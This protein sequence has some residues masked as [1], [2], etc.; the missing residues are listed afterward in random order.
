MML[1]FAKPEVRQWAHAVVDRLVQNYELE[2]IKI[3][4]NIDVGSEFDPAAQQ[5][6]PVPCCWI[7]S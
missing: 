3:D 7:T 2:W 1:N 5:S 4:Y 6:A